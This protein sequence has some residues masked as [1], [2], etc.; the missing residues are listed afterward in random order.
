MDGQRHFG[1]DDMMTYIDWFM[2]SSSLSL[3]EVNCDIDLETCQ[4]IRKSDPYVDWNTVDRSFF[5][6]MCLDCQE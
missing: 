5:E 3:E 2:L 4:Q 6:K 1:E